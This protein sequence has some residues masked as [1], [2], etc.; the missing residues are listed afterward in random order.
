MGRI[1]RSR[2]VVTAET[3]RTTLFEIFFDL[4]FVFGFIRVTEFMIA[5]PA[6]VT[7][8][9]G[10][11]VLLL[12]W[13]SW[14]VYSWLGNQARIDVGL[15]RAGVT[16]GMAAV[17]LAALVIPDV[18]ES[19]PGALGPRLILVMAY[20]VVRVIHLVLYHWAAVGS[21]RLLR[22]IRVYAL[23]TPLSWVPLVLGAVF[24]GTAQILLWTAALVVDMGGGVVASVL[25]GW[26]V[27]SPGHFTER[28]SL[29]VIIALGESLIS[30]GT[31]VGAEMMIRG[32]VL[33]A[34][35]LTLAATV[36]LYWLYARSAAA[37]RQALTMNFGLRRDQV[38]ANA[39]TVAHFPLIAG[40][41]YLAL[42]VE[43]VLAG[44]AHDESH[45]TDALNWIPAV[46]LFGGTALYLAGRATFLSFSV[47]SVRPWQ[48]LA[49]GVALLLLPAGRY[50]PGLTALGLLTTFLVVLVSYE[51]VAGRGRG[52]G[53]RSDP[54][55][56]AR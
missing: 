16:V 55:L 54:E 18:W 6:P 26:P 23:T 7:L 51:A 27:R 19:G 9:Q 34:A 1:F 38:A 43:Q 12:L 13:N 2:P 17:F 24:G 22:T 4:V 44:L 41:I 56:T 46:A 35:L 29:V 3:H 5:R 39:Y 47:R 49:P 10:F 48:F 28:H 15:I 25:S 52:P 37:A 45:G 50:L 40:I 53:A 14:L 20:I 21:P 31:G 30:V 42:G 11:I 8:V 36:C 32:P 33:V